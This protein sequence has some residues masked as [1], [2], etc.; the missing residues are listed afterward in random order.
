MSFDLKHSL[1]VPAG[2]FLIL[3]NS[4]DAQAQHLSYNDWKHLGEESCAV[5]VAD[6]VQGM[7]HVIDTEKY[8]MQVRGPDGNLTG[9]WNP[10]G[11]T[12]GILA[13]VR[14]AEVLKADGKINPGGTVGV[15]VYGYVGSDLPDEPLDKEKRVFFLRPLDPNGKEFT[16]AVTQIIERAEQNGHPRYTDR[17]VR[18]DPKGCYTPVE[19]G[20]AQVLVPPNKTEIIDKIKRAIAQNR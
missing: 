4:P 9:N 10:A 1:M 20:Y 8:R 13:R 17:S 7:L 2:L 14:I 6:V 19:S 18:F 15:L 3:V 5:V 11:Y 16:H 12:V